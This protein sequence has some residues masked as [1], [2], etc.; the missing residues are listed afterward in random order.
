VSGPVT[1]ADIPPEVEVPAASVGTVEISDCR[2]W[3]NFVA[4]TRDEIT[5]AH[6]DWA[7]SAERF[8]T[9]DSALPRIDVDPPPWRRP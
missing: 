5:V 2:E 1:T 7:A 9:V 6:T 3:W 8:G 4:R